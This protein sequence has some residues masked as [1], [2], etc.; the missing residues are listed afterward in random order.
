[1][2]TSLKDKIIKLRADGYNYEEICFELKCAKSTVSYHCKNENVGG[3][4]KIILS[5]E[6]ILNIRKL[7]KERISANKISE[8]L[9]I[10]LYQVKNETKKVKRNLIGSSGAVISWRKRL[11]LKLVEYKGGKCENCRYNKCLEALQF[12]HMDPKEKSF[13][14]SGTSWSFVR[15]KEEVDKCKLLCANC[16]I[17][18]HNTL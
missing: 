13:N 1:M 12:H 4:K 9:D 16:H 15:M 2:N 3:K 18:Y 8:L 10:K 6:Q 14:I 11:K 5:N 7:F 17:E